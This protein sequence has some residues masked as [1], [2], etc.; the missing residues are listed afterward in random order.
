[1]ISLFSSFSIA[2]P[3]SSAELLEKNCVLAVLS[4]W[5]WEERKGCGTVCS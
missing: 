1:M 2:T 5:R 4:F 3:C